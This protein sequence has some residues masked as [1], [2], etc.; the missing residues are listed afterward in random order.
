MKVCGGIIRNSKLFLTS[1]LDGCERSVL[2]HFCFTPWNPLNR[3]VGAL[4][5]LHVLEKTLPDDV[6]I[7]FVY[8]DLRKSR[9]PH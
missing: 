6:E 7:M 2:A 4:Q 9:F 5:R 8:C 1:P 3:K